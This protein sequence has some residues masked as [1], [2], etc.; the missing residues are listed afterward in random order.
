MIERPAFGVMLLSVLV[1]GGCAPQGVAPQ[2]A[3]PKAGQAEPAT[4]STATPS[5]RKADNDDHG[6]GPHG[7]IIS[8]WGRLHIEL[9]FDRVKKEAVVYLLAGDEETPKSI[10][11]DDRML[12]LT[13]GD[14]LTQVELKAA[15]L[16]GEMDGHSSRF[17]GEAG[18]IDLSRELTVNVSGTVG[19]VP[20][21]AVFHY[22]PR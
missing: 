10:A 5:A 7:G 3:V 16:D 11:A 20:H 14:P 4:P 6:D 8:H 1:I 21:T 2:T 18:A 15:P 12:Q 17:V 13:V 22:V 19:G 9:A